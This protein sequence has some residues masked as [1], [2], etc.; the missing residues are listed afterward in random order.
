M[1]NELT[2]VWGNIKKRAGIGKSFRL[3]DAS[4]HSF[5][6]QLIDKGANL[7]RIRAFFAIDLT[8]QS[9]ALRVRHLSSYGPCFPIVLNI[10]WSESHSH[11]LSDSPGWQREFQFLMGFV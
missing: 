9:T 11:R 10:G 7:F 3:Y 1:G 4:R 6:S 2:R 8:R 5:G